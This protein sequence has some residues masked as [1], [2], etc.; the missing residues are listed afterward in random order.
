MDVKDERIMD[1]IRAFAK[2]NFLVSSPYW[3]LM[4]SDMPYSDF[5]SYVKKLK[6][7]LEQ[8]DPTAPAVFPEFLDSKFGFECNHN[9]E[10]FQHAFKKIC[11]VSLEVLQRQLKDFFGDGI[12]AGEVPQD[13]VDVLRTCP[14][15][16]LI[17]ERLFGDL[18]FDMSKKRKA[19]LHLRTS[20]NMW[21]HNRTSQWIHKKKNKKLFI[22]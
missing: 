2:F 7:F 3:K 20:I 22:F 19:S 1:M 11:S 6:D 9:S 13:I 4:N 16:N 18:D 12:F 21:K 5:H 15:T 17:G 14:L 8:S 10:F